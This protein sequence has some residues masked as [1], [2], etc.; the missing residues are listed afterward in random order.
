LITPL[1]VAPETLKYEFPVML[2]FAFLMLPLLLRE[3]GVGRA[4][5]VIAGAAYAAF[6]VIAF[7]RPG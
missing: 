7:S 6:L 4:W 2:F 1:H 5:G 3:K